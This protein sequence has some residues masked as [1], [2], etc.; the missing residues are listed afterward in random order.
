ML[1]L[2]NEEGVTRSAALQDFQPTLD[3]TVR[4][5]AK[6]L[7][8]DFPVQRGIDYVQGLGST[9][10]PGGYWM[11]A[12]K[13]DTNRAR[14]IAKEYGDNTVAV[15]GSA[16]SEQAAR[17]QYERQR[18]R[19]IADEVDRNTRFD[20]Y[21]TPVRA[22]AR[23]ATTLADPLNIASM[24]IPVIGPEW[25]AGRIAAASGAFGRFV[26]R[27]ESG[28]IQGAVGMGAL[29]AVNIPLAHA[30]GDEQTLMDSVSNIALGAFLGAALHGTIGGIFG[31]IPARAADAPRVREETPGIRYRDE[32]PPQVQAA[33]VEVNMAAAKTVVAQMAQ[34]QP[35]NVEHIYSTVPAH[36][37]PA[38]TD[39][40]KAKTGEQFE[41][42][43]MRGQGRDG[44]PYNP[45]VPQEGVLGTGR[46][47]TNDKEFASWFGPQITEHQVRLENP[48]VI[49]DDVQWRA[50][51]EDAGWEFP[52]P[53]S[54]T[55]NTTKQ[56][57]DIARLR[58][59]IEERGYD[60]VIVQ[61]PK[62]EADGK[63]MQNVF[64]A[65]QVIEFN[66]KSPQI[67]DVAQSLDELRTRITENKKQN[68]LDGEGGTPRE[69]SL[70]VDTPTAET[71]PDL[72]LAKKL[73]TD[74][75]AR[76]TGMTKSLED[77]GFKV[78]P[79]AELVA[80]DKAA[81]QADA[82]AKAFIA[83]AECKGM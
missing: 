45:L 9:Q 61:V 43:L 46:Y 66:A 23:V 75:K 80:A 49:S 27:A 42:V 12:P 1:L 2:D 24:F 30:I 67:Q 51:T 31:R 11:D 65:S 82:E 83:I 77:R 78:K 63:T 13:V 76:L 3:Y 8:D 7:W 22:L 20:P 57:A 34:D 53:I 48:L 62:S 68:I 56:S 5:A 64:G 44:S 14:E 36:S 52:N 70:K 29:E 50:L 39:I 59:I 19:R 74:A 55:G 71:N 81:T 21:E 18:Q 58:S 35:V 41:T 47:T 38:V 54:M 28:A 73:E 37:S 4:L 79:D 26:A 25:T 17:I 16:F 40:A 72:V 32:R 33:P 10:Q 15:A 69:V 60:G 6:R